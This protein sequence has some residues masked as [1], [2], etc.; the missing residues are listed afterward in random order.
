MQQNGILFG[1][2][3]T[4]KELGPTKTVWRWGVRSE[5]WGWGQRYY[6]GRI[7]VMKDLAKIFEVWINSVNRW[8]ISM[9]SLLTTIVIIMI[10]QTITTLTLSQYQLF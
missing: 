4:V 1:F 6:K 2:K 7:L 3:G 8:M 5:E 9:I 10:N